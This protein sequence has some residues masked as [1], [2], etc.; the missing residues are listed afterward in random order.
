MVAE[1]F[2]GIG[3]LK[4]AF[5]I[6]KG[7][8]DI[9][10]AARRNAAVIELQEKILSAQE[11]Q[12]TLVERVRE[13][14][15]KVASLEQWEAEKKRYALTDFGGSSFAYL[16]K[17]EAANGEPSHRIC[18]TCY[19][20][21]QKSILQYRFRAATGRDKWRCNSCDRDLEFGHPQPSQQS[22]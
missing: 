2:A 1:V 4:T 11:A 3:A 14:E 8:K 19:E 22:R 5:D 12:A 13:L 16:L 6:A 21:R 9:D 20:K 17:P 7:L 18:P 10:D 15:S